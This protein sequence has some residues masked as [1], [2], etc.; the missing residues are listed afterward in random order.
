MMEINLPLN[1]NATLAAKTNPA[2]GLDLKINQVLDAKV[3][4][5]QIAL[6][7]LTVK[8]ADKTLTLQAQQPLPPQDMQAGQRLQLLVVKLLP[9][10]EFKVLPQADNP[11]AKAP[12]QTPTPAPSQ[13]AGALLKL[14]PQPQ[15]A[16]GNA[17]QNPS[18]LPALAADKLLQGQR[19]QAVVV[20]SGQNKLTLEVQLLPGTGKEAVLPQ[21]GPDGKASLTV[22]TKQL[23]TLP[24]TG[25]ATANLTGAAAD[26]TPA[27]AL[28]AL[29]AG[30]TL[31]LQVVKPGREPTFAISS[32]AIAEHDMAETLKQLLPIQSSPAPL[33]NQL[34][35]IPL[36]SGPNPTVAETLRQLAQEILR[37]IPQQTKL[38]EPQQL[39]Q[40]VDDSGLFLERKLAE[41][42]NGKELPLQDDFKFKLNKLA[43][44]LQSELSN[45]AA[46]AANPEK[47]NLEEALQKTQGALAK[48]TL[49]QLA[50]LPK[51]DTGKQSWLVELPFFRDGETETVQIEIERDQAGGDPE[52]ARE[53][54]AVSITITPPNL[55][56]I[57]CRISCYDGSINAR[58]R[59]EAEGTVDLINAHLDYLKQQFESK[60]LSAGFLD[61]QQGGTLSNGNVQAPSRHLLNEKA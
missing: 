31:E 13:A 6:D 35:R 34:S 21:T 57:H 53:N 8:V 27:T 52:Q 46:E 28:R 47:Q 16:A 41:M 25:G 24:Q 44:F 32:P 23:R 42:L 22:D 50:S 43:Q 9:L 29:S 18:P 14:V 4:Q 15:A 20:E 33:L 48:L 19:L 61:A 49:D 60:G 2:S 59:S 5:T 45:R 38:A 51:E 17:S 11:T 26:K 56:T 10:P 12:P 1:A 30:Q 55:A 3:V 39:K 40:A 36:E 54:W 7:T 58:F 37:G